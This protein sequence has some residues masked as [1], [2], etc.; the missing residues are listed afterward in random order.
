MQKEE[1]KKRKEEKST[2]PGTQE[3]R[4]NSRT[5]MHQTLR[6]CKEGGD[7]KGGGETKELKIAQ[8]AAFF[9]EIILFFYPAVSFHKQDYLFISPSLHSTFYL[10]FLF[11][12]HHSTHPHISF[13]C[14]V[15]TK[16]KHPKPRKK[17]PETNSLDASRNVL[18]CYSSL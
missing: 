1:R 6:L 3:V 9:P 10:C 11:C 17:T 13:K 14:K 2:S 8:G 7:G 4:E 15:K 12:Q 18:R 5:D 16:T